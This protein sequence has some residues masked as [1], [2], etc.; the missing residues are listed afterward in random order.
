M[1]T[2]TIDSENN[3]TAHAGPPAAADESQ[4]FSTPKGL[5]SSVLHDKSLPW[6]QRLWP[7][8]IRCSGFSDCVLGALFPGVISHSVLG[9]GCQEFGTFQAL[10]CGE[11][12]SP[13]EGGS[14]VH[15]D[16][17]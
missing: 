6:L 7:P 2:F 10:L 11:A 8:G 5:A 1:A 14:T 12:V 13:V 3:I 4:S 15:G 17:S 9:V 16:Y